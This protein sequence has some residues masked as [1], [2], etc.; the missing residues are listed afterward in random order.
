[1]KFAVLVLAIAMP[2]AIAQS[3]TQQSYAIHNYQLHYATSQSEQNEILTAIRNIGAQGMRIFLVPSQSQIVVSGSPEQNEQVSQLLRMLDVPAPLYRLTYIFTETENGKRIGI[4][5]YS[6]VLAPA[7]RMQLKE[8]DR[9]PVMTG[10]VGTDPIAKQTSYVDVG[11]S[12]EATVTAYGSEGVRLQTKV[13]RSA[14]AQEK[15]SVL[16][17][18]PLIRQSMINGVVNLTLNKPQHLGNIDVIGSTRQLQIDGLVEV[19]K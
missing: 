17:A 8:G 10:T 16:A 1:M 3:N 11:F 13:E 9:V 7:Q 5:Q 12:F 19:V 14:I 6:M 2:A 15:T 18:D 4:Q